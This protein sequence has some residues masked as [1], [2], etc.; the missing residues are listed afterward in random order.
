MDPK[1]PRLVLAEGCVLKDRGALAED[2]EK[3]KEFLKD[4]EPC[5]V[6][7]C[8]KDDKNT[9]PDADDRTWIVIHWVPEDSPAR[10]KLM[11]STAAKSI[12]EGLMNS[13]LGF[14]TASSKGEVT[15]EA[16]LEAG[17]Q[18]VKSG[19]TS[20]HSTALLAEIAAKRKD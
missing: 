14:L 3:C 13:K 12:T 1:R 19:S 6:F 4:G 10:T 17:V 5:S 18:A 20:R 9:V 16:L 15:K 8:A 7:V 11:W 2:F